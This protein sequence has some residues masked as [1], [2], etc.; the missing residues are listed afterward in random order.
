MGLFLG[1]SIL[2]LFEIVVWMAKALSSMLL[3]SKSSFPTKRKVNN[4]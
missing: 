3:G 4:V 2:S 1:M